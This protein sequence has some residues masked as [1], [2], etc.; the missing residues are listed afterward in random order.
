MLKLQTLILTVYL[1]MALEN[2][3]FSN[4]SLPIGLTLLNLRGATQNLR[5]SIISSDPELIVARRKE[6]SEVIRK[7]SGFCY[8]QPINDSLVILRLTNNLQEAIK[9]AMTTLN[10]AS[11]RLSANLA[12]A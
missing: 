2:Y 5:D 6:L 3:D 12:L 11:S 1:I 7:L 4:T 9:T 10:D 8:K